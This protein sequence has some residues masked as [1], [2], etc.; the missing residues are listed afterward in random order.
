MLT[1]AADFVIPEWE[2]PG[3]LPL[4]E[5]EAGDHMKRTLASS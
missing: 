1:L 2:Q 4:T 3:I 5:D